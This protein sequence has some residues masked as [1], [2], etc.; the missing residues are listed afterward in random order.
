MNKF[1]KLSTWKQIIEST[2]L[3]YQ[4][5]N[6]EWYKERKK[7]C[8]DCPLNSKFIVRKTFKDKL[9]NFLYLKKDYCQACLCILH[10]KQSIPEAYCGMEEIGQEPKWKSIL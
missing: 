5:R 4:N 7:I 8:D 9:L 2:W 10:K 6:K 1:L 3:Y